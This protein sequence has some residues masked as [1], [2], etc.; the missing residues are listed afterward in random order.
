MEV[1]NN[2]K[3]KKVD[4]KVSDEWMSAIY[5]CLVLNRDMPRHR[6]HRH[7]TSQRHL[8]L[9]PDITRHN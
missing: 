1:D 9:G 6:C 4:K 8:V 2:N 5:N 7:E 3:N